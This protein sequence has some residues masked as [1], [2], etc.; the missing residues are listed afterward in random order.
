M[1][2]SGVLPL[3]EGN[4]E[5]Q[6]INNNKT[7]LIILEGGFVCDCAAFTLSICSPTTSG[8]STAIKGSTAPTIQ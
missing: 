4:L 5:Y 1:L 8:R 7:N 3:H 6:L 2:V